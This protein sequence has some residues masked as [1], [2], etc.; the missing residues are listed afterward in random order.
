MAAAI[1]AH[2]T[3]ASH[4]LAAGLDGI[5]LQMGH[6]HLLAQFLSPLSNVRTDAYGGSLEHR[7]RFP[8]AVLAAVRAAVG[9][10]VCL[11][12]RVSGDEFVEG[13]LHL[14]EAVEIVGALAARTRVDFV[15]V[16]H[17]AYHGSASLATQIADMAHDPVPFR[18]LPRTIRTS[19][20]ARG[21]EVPVLAV[22]RFTSLREADAAISAGVADAVGMARAHIADPAL[23]RKTL[24][25]RADEVT[26]CIGC[27]QGCAARLEKN[28]PITCLVN[29]RAGRER[30]WPEPADDPSPAPRRVLVVGGGPAGMEAAWVAAARGHEVELWE[31]GPQLGGQ[32]LVRELRVEARPHAIGDCVAPRTALEAIYQGRELARAL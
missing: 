25:G 15:N 5:E 13:G 21:L 28:I 8:A 22:C 26:P 10:E 12:I 7:L 11:G 32:L 9:E 30:T 19:L 16:S 17:S 24:A 14:P 2:V 3:T 6:G 20:R 23:V 18:E 1:D 4:L 29:P 27:N 31:A